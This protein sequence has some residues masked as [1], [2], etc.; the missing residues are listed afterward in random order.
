MAEKIEAAREAKAIVK[1]KQ[2]EEKRKQEKVAS[3]EAKEA[4]SASEEKKAA[5]SAKKEAKKA[6]DEKA[7]EKFFTFSLKKSRRAPKCDR[8]RAAMKALKQQ[9]EKH[10]KK[11]VLVDRSL[12]DVIWSRGIKSAP[13]KI[14]VKVRIT[15]D[16]ATAYP[17][18]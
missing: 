8:S 13:S 14:K 6:E 17:V 7:E 16:K 2:K 10:V 4:K 11:Q 15:K 1:E 5:E 18:K 12:N 3:E 9:L